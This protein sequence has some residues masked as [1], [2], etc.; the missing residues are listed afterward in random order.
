MRQRGCLSADCEA[1]SA[2]CHSV[3]SSDLH[4]TD[5]E[6]CHCHTGSNMTGKRRSSNGLVVEPSLRNAGVTGSSPVSGTTFFMALP[7]GT[8]AAEAEVSFRWVAVWVLLGALWIGKRAQP[9]LYRFEGWGSADSYDGCT[10]RINNAATCLGGDQF[11]DLGCH[12][13]HR[14][15]GCV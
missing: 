3:L 4:G 2:G 9:T 12:I 5:C 8:A 1:R 10:P 11:G 7:Q 14:L 13:C 6:H 15:F